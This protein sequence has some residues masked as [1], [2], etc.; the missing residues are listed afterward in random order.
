MSYRGT[1]AIRWDDACRELVQQ[2]TDKLIADGMTRPNIRAVLY[3]LLRIPGWSKKT[4]NHLTEKLGQW[5]DEGKF[6]YGVFADDSGARD[7]PFTA[8]EIARQIEI[9]QTATPASLPADGWLRVLLVEHQALVSQIED[10]CDHQALVVSSAGQI[11]RENLWTAVGDWKSMLAELGGAGIRV[12]ALMDRDDG[13]DKIYE[14]HR[15]WFEQVA[16]LELRFYGL[17]DAQLLRFGLDAA[18]K[19]QIDGVVGLDPGWWREQVR[20]LLLS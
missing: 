5:R 3:Q 2:T 15:R 14:A 16:G 12:Y 20:E 8:Q 10:W 1:K 9:W 11:R 4:Y 19:W 6:D 7:R 18:E 17:T 13:G